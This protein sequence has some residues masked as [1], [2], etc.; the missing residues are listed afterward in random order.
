VRKNNI[1]E[2]TREALE[3]AL[4]L[5]ATAPDDELMIE[6]AGV[7]LQLCRLLPEDEVADAMRAVEQRL[8]DED[9][10]GYDEC[11]TIQ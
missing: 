10:E 3:L 2:N 6:A 4:Y 8:H 1:P 9:E 5:A 7:S 11:I